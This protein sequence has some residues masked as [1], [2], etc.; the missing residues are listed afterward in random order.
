MQNHIFV[1]WSTWTPKLSDT[2]FDG[3][4]LKERQV[5]IIFLAYFMDFKNGLTK[6]KLINIVPIDF[7]SLQKTEKMRRGV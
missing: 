5:K 2:E 6:K 1:L 7:D 3:F 4:Y